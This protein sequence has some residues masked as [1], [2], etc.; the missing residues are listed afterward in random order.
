M[1]EGEVIERRDVVAA[2]GDMDAGPSLNVLEHPL[3]DGFDLDEHLKSIQRHYLR[4]AMGEARGVKAR[5]AKL[6]G[7]K[8]YQTLDAQLQRLQVEWSAP[9]D[10]V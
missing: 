5:A 6:L 3:G 2:V 8:N 7:M 10:A 9:A 1:A 4:R